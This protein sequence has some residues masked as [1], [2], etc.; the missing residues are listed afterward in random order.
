MH[1]VGEI[2]QKIGWCP[3]LS[4]V[5]LV[6]EILDSQFSWAVVLRKCFRCDQ[7][8]R[9]EGEGEASNK[10]ALYVNHTGCSLAKQSRIKE[11]KITETCSGMFY[12]ANCHCQLET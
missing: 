4:L 3:P 10:E 6:W 9:R 7:L 8:G 12:C 11:R 5:P 1:L 2:R